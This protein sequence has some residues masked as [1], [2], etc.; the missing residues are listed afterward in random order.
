MDYLLLFLAVLCFTGQFAFTKLFEGTVKQNRLTALIMLMVTNTIGFVLFFCLSGFQIRFTPV[1]AL[2]ALAMGVIMI[3]YYTL[4]IRVLSLGSLAVYS[5]FMMLGGM[6]VPFFYG[7][8]FLYEPLTWGKG[9]GTV[10][11]SL[12]I[13]LQTMTPGG[14]K[15]EKTPHKRLFLG[16]CMVIFLINGMTGVIAKA[17]QISAAPIPETDFT[18]LSCGITCL[19]SLGMLTLE[20]GSKR[21]V[22]GA[23]LRKKTLFIM[24]GLGV[25][26]YGGSFLHLAA[27]ETVP[28]SVQFPMVSGGVIVLSALVSA[29]LFGEK[30]SR[31]EW[32]C[33]GGAF[34]STCL[35]A[36]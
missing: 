1:A 2:L 32:L 7:V 27:A 5:M 26:A 19:L 13:I 9:L 31:R 34:L 23:V 4:G 21:E 25:A 12:C 36:F 20:K 30:V 16:L 29:F 33:V 15:Q 17:H 35:F 10:L 18:A 14:T 3:P 22:I 11:L 6:L 24:V 28:A 8:V